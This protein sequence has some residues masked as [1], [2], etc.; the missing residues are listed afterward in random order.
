M[1]HA[2]KAKEGESGKQDISTHTPPGD[3]VTVAQ[4][5]NVIG[6]GEEENGRAVVA[7]RVSTSSGCRNRSSCI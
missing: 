5:A 3:R 2:P 7:G 4:R 6:S 1:A